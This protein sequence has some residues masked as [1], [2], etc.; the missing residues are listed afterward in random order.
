MTGFLGVLIRT[1][2]PA[3]FGN[4]QPPLKTR[5]SPGNQPNSNFDQL[6]ERR[7][8]WHS[9]NQVGSMSTPLVWSCL[10]S[11]RPFWSPE[12]KKKRQS[13][14][15]EWRPFWI[16]KFSWKLNQT[17]ADSPVMNRRRDRV[18]V[19]FQGETKEKPTLHFRF[20]RNAWKEKI[21]ICK[22]NNLRSRWSNEQLVLN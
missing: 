18:T 3:Q 10:W 2:R 6:R 8:L 11:E 5:K 16:Q 4:E 9:S 22:L 12:R 1:N 7:I 14:F 19:Q 15:S 13:D 20:P 17:E 21:G